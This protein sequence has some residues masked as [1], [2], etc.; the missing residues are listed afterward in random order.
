[1]TILRPPVDGVWCQGQATEGPHRLEPATVHPWTESGVKG[2]IAPNP[3]LR[4]RSR[5]HCR[6]GSCSLHEPAAYLIDPVRA[7]R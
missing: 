3:C 1:M 2:E 6:L 4:R 7:N 5:E